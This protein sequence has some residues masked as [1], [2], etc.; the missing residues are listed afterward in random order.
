MKF[1]RVYRADWDCLSTKTVTLPNTD[2]CSYLVLGPNDTSGGCVITPLQPNDLN[3]QSIVVTVDA[4]FVGLIKGPFTI[5][6]L[7]VATFGI[8]Q[9]TLD[10]LIYDCPQPIVQKRGLYVAAGVFLTAGE[11]R[12]YPC[13]GRKRVSIAMCGEAQKE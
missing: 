7:L 5:T 4:P 3:G 9:C 10:L 8:A 11:T 6:P 12:V 13:F 2:G 1:Q